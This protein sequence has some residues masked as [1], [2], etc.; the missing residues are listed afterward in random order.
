MHRFLLPA[1]LLLIAAFAAAWFYFRGEDYV[2][3]LREEDIRQQLD[4][5][6]PLKRTFLRIFEV[7][8]AHARVQL[9]DGSDRIDVGV[10]V[11]LSLHIGHETR[12]LGGSVDLETGIRYE[13]ANGGFYLTD[14]LVKRLDLQ[15]VPAEYEARAQRVV[16]EVLREFL[17]LRP[18]YTLR[19]VDAKRAAARLLLERVVVENRELVV[20]LGI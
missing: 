10:D 15:G 13:P 18:V 2:V 19:A 9:H 14:P 4:R 5:Q 11:Q 20:T 17:R 8:L 3:R 6:L 12:P 7:E 1:S 16:G